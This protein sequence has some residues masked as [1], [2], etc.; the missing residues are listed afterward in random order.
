MN[1]KY[2]QRSKG[3]IAVLILSF[4][5][6]LFGIFS[7]YLDANFTVLQQLYIRAF[8]ALLI[9]TCVFYKDLNFNKIRNMPSKEWGVLALRSLFLYGFG[10]TIYINALLLTTYSNVSFLGAI[11]MTAVL[12]FA[13]LQEKLTFKK[14][15]I[16]IIACIGI[17][18]IS[19]KDFSQGFHWGRGEILALI[20]DIFFSLGYVTRRWHTDYLNNKEITT[21]IFLFGFIIL[22]ILSLIFDRSFPTTGWTLN[23]FYAIAAVAALS[24]T[25]QFLINYGFTRVE[26]SLA[27]NIIA[28]ESIFAVVIGLLLYKEIPI[29]RELL[30]GIL[31]LLSVPLMNKAEEEK[32]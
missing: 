11:P 24:V 27:S 31:I 4:T 29:L 3:I 10:A 2:S 30:G 32:N 8:T 19:S 26:P 21:F 17:I 13:F 20:A 5:F 23:Y 15:L 9:S 12:G 7:R 16:L 22:F 14:L 28:L 6:S 18:L 25:N 1:S